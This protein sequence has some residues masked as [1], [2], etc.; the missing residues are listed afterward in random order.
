MIP[1]LFTVG[2][3]LAGF[4]SVLHA[5]EGRLELAGMLIILAGFLDGL[6]GRIA[7]LDATPPRNSARST[8]RW[9]TW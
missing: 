4:A 1:S 9:P 5:I 6:D 8:T 7:R 2:N 3:M